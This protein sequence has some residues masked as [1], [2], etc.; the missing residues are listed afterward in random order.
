MYL[1]KLELAGRN[2]CIKGSVNVLRNDVAIIGTCRYRWNERRLLG[3]TTSSPVAPITEY[4]DSTV[5]SDDKD[6]FGIFHY[7]TNKGSVKCYNV[8]LKLTTIKM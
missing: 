2:R 3:K 7:K 6:V 4:Q 8:P 5:I 1:Q